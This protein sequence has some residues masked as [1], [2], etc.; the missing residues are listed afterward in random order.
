MASSKNKV[1]ITFTNELKGTK[2][3]EKVVE[4]Y[5]ET[6]TRDLAKALNKSTPNDV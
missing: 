3:S 5:T 1:G 4:I 2:S 6:D